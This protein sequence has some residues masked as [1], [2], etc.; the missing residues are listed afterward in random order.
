MLLVQKVL[1]APKL[2]EVVGLS[3]KHPLPVIATPVIDGQGVVESVNVTATVPLTLGELLKS[4]EAEVVPDPVLECVEYTVSLESWEGEGDPL[5]A[6][7]GVVD[8]EL[9]KDPLAAPLT[10]KGAVKVAK[11]V[12]SALLLAELVSSSEEGVGG[13]V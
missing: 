8:G 1:V 5:P 6:F 4:G 12:A 10:V 2:I 9:L 13:G 11:G 3:L 7:E